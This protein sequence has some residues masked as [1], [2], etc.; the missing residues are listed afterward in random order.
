[1]RGKKRGSGGWK[2]LKKSANGLVGKDTGRPMVTKNSL[3]GEK[4]DKRSAIEG[5]G[6]GLE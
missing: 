5:G 2:G 3:R 1:L 6:L 4:E